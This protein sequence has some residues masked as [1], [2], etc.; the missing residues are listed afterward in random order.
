VVAGLLLAAVTGSSSTRTD[1]PPNIPLNYLDCV[2][3]SP[4]KLATYYFDYNPLY[5]WL[6][7][8]DEALTG[9]PVIIKDIQLSREMLEMENARTMRISEDVVIELV[10]THQLDGFK[11]GDTVDIVGL[12]KGLSDTRSDVVLAE[13]YIESAG[14]LNLPLDGKSPQDLLGY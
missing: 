2:E 8:G 12:C 9:K 3:L 4:E 10:S 13:S 6:P 5:F 7:T 14:I 1:P 11:T